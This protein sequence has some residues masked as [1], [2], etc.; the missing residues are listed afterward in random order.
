MD[1]FAEVV[2]GIVASVVPIEQELDRAL[3][4]V[5]GALPADER[6][7]WLS[8]ARA[9][10]AE[11]REELSRRVEPLL[12][13]LKDCLGLATRSELADLAARVERLERKGDA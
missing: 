8:E 12:A 10:L 9:A 3:A 2:A 13:A 11:R 5:A 4:E 1:P 7:K 6:E